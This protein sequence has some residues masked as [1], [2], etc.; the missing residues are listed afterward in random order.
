[1]RISD[2]LSQGMV[3]ANLD[4]ATKDALLC[5]I[6]EHLCGHP[7][8]SSDPASVHSALTNRERLGSTGVGEGVAIPHAKVPSLSELTACFVR[9]PKGV[10][11]DA[12]DQ[13][14]VCLIFA[15]LVPEHSAGAHLKALARISRLLRNSDFREA[16]LKEESSASLY[17]AFLSEDSQL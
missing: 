2:I 13:K 7:S 15:L 14:P 11:F 16:L 3:V 1:M 6:A 12:I 10:P 17:Q 5:K 9:V 8:V 4:V